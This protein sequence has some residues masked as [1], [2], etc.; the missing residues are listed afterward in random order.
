MSGALA[1]GV[2]LVTAFVGVSSAG[3]AN[4]LNAKMCQKNGWTTLVRA[5]GTTFTSEQAC[6]SYAAKGGVLKRPQTVA[7]TSANPSPVTVG[8]TYTPT[9]SATSGLTAAITLDA[10]STG[11]SLAS[12]IVTFT[13]GGTCKIDANQAGNSIYNAASQVQQSITVNKAS[14]TVAFTSANPSPVLVGATYTPTAAA[15]SALSVAITLDAAST[16]CSLASGIVTFTARG[17]C[18]IDANQAG[19]GTYNAASQVQQSVTVKSAAQVR[20]ESFGG[21]FDTPFT[22]WTCNG[23]SALTQ[24]TWETPLFLGCIVDDGGFFF[25]AF[26]SGF[27]LVDTS[28]IG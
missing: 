9:A 11:C 13:A 22:L 3:A 18:V 20:C 7:F 17:T 26:E 15:T 24:G 19:N 5:N 8:A 25:D 2:L 1:G 14:Q 6:V 12:G 27:L 10:A 28:C 16:G 4:S 23:L 21:T